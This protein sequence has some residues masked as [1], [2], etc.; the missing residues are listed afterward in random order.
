M[1]NFKSWFLW[2]ALGIII[3][4]SL[5]IIY[6]L[7][8]DCYLIGDKLHIPK[9]KIEKVSITNDEDEVALKSQD[10][11]KRLIELL[12]NLRFDKEYSV[13]IPS[14]WSYHVNLSIKNSEKKYNLLFVGNAVRYKERWYS[15]QE[16]T[17][18]KIRD[19]Y[20]NY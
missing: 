2:A 18:I 11:Q 4:V 17:L 10:D 20:E 8:P 6:L 3:T 9:D 12:E 14:G 1:P 16:S 5:V 19:L 13:G 15:V 7:K